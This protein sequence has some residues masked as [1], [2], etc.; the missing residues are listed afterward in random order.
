[1]RSRFDRNP[2]KKRMLKLSQ[3]QDYPNF[4]YGNLLP[5][6]ADVP[7]WKRSFVCG[8][9]LLGV[10]EDLVFAGIVPQTSRQ[11]FVEA[12]ETAF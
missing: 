8:G 6:F 2:F 11:R 4:L 9:K 10:R 5:V 3:N 12:E 7:V 1:M